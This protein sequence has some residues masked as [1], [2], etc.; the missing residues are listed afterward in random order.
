[1]GG[2]SNSQ[3][4]SMLC[5][6]LKF[7]WTYPAEL[8]SKRSKIHDSRNFLAIKQVLKGKL[9]DFAIARPTL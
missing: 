9:T 7:K 5:D 6:K 3:V 1:M 4:S 2:A 8:P